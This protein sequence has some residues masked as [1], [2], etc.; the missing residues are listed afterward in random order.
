MFL[1]SNQKKTYKAHILKSDL[2]QVVEVRTPPRKTV[3]TALNAGAYLQWR[4]VSYT[5]A[6]REVTGSTAT[7]QYAPKKLSN[8]TNAIDCTMLYTYYGNDTNDL[9]LQTLTI[10]L[11]SK[12]DGFYRKTSYAT[13]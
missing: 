7:M 1:F 4:P 9:L 5:S 6:S 3:D 10:S 13:W 2:L 12:G 8:R 11:G